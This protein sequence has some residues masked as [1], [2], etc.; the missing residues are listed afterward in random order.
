MTLTDLLPTLR[1]SIADPL[2]VDAWPAGTRAAVG[3]VAVGG[4]SLARLA[5]LQGTPC[6]CST[7]AAVPCTGG[8]P[9]PSHRAGAVVVAVRAIDETGAVAVGADLAGTSLACADVALRWTEAR[10]IGRASTARR[11][12]TPVGGGCALLPV[13]LRVGDLLAVPTEAWAEVQDGADARTRRHA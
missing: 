6:A 12:S 7:A 9:S 8:R 10:L 3:D 2:D 4:R 11:A 5:A 13:D 1:A